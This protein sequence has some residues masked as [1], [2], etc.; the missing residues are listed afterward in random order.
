VL[1]MN[2]LLIRSPLTSE[3]RVCAETVQASGQHLLAI[4]NNIL[5]FSR[6]ESGHLQLEAI[7]FNLGDLVQSAL[8]MFGLPAHAKGLDLR[9]NLAPEDGALMLRGDPLRLRQIL[10]NLLGNAIKFTA[11]GEVVL[12]VYCRMSTPEEVNIRMVVK[13]T[14]VGISSQAL[15]KIFDFFRKPT[16]PPRASSAGLAWVWRFASA[17]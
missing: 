12:S 4:I 11:H 13:D 9:V 3:Q 16:V 7:D 10:V 15:G 2:D 14:G 1:G 6:I 8:L 5:D 17:C